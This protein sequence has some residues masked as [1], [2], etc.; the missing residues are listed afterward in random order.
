MV[1]TTGTAA[2]LATESNLR[3]VEALAEAYLGER[4][5]EVSHHPLGLT[6]SLTAAMEEE[7]EGVAVL[8]Q[9]HSSNAGDL[10]I[11]VKRLR[12]QGW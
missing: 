3:Q 10:Q 8:L 9:L 5:V 1:I 6:N 7:E 11:G 12:A 2:D 4:V